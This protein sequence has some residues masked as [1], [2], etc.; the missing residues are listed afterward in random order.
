MPSPGAGEAGLSPQAPWHFILADSRRVFQPLGLNQMIF[1]PPF[2]C[3]LLVVFFILFGGGVGAVS[4]EWD[5][6]TFLL[7][8]LLC[9][10]ALGSRGCSG[11]GL[12]CLTC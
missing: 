5:W 3:F 12:L 9:S 6:G 1:F 2:F 10:P 4:S 11:V 7:F 8:P